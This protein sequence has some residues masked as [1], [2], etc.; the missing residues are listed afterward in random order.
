MSLALVPDGSRF[1]PDLCVSPKL[2][3]NDQE[4]VVRMTE[5]PLLAVEIDEIFDEE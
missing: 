4:D 2:E 5:P 1:T 3:V